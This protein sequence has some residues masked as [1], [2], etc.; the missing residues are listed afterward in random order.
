MCYTLTALNIL[1]HNGGILTEQKAASNKWICSDF[2]I[3]TIN[4]TT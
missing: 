4:V 3:D 1:T 2:V